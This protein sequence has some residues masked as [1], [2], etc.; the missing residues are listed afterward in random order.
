MSINFN[1]DEIL[2][3]AQQ[4]EQNGLSFYKAAAN[5]VTD[6]EAKQMLSDLAEW[7]AGHE[8]L[9]R[10]MRARLTEEQRQPMVFDPYDEMGLYLK[11]TASQVVFTSK[12]DP[13]E[14]IGANPSFRR[15]LDIA[16]ERER[17][18]VVFYAGIKKFVPASLGKDKIEGILQ[19]EV[20]HVAMITQRLAEIE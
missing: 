5:A 7:E 2:E 20:S 16:I 1:A 11:A 12:M 9:F 6:P 3:I 10:D 4:I 13:A 8:K 14:M 18:A 17:D 15:I 19:E